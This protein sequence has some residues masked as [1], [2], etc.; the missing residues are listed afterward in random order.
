MMKYLVWLFALLITPF[1]YSQSVA[2]QGVN[3]N[4]QGDVVYLGTT[5][6]T[7]TTTVVPATGSGAITVSTPPPR[8]VRFGNSVLG[9]PQGYYSD[10]KTLVTNMLQIVLIL[11]VLMV[12]FQLVS[13][14]VNWIT[15]GGDKAKTD[16]ARSKIVAAVV[17]LVIVI[18]S[19]AIFLFI[20]QLLGLDPSSI[21]T[22]GG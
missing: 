6:T 3:V 2:A 19:W 1:L 21:I 5:T 4:Q 22:I 18:A 14:G 7:T 16:S 13:A 10:F 15:S 11:S 8:P 17:G 20:L 12:L 9:I